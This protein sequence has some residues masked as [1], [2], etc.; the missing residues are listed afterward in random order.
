[1]KS[2]YHAAFV[3]V[4]LVSALETRPLR[5]EALLCESKSAEPVHS[6][7]DCAWNAEAFR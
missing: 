2:K 7:Q 4:W 3:M 6:R 1:M 5:I